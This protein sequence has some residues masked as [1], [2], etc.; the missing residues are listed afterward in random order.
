MTA[1]QIR[2]YT[3]FFAFSL[4][5]LSGLF[6]LVI[7]LLRLS[8]ENFAFDWRESFYGAIW[9]TDFGWET[10][11]FRVPPWSIPFFIPLTAL[12]FNIGWAVMMAFTTISLVLVVPRFPKNVQ[13]AGL[14]L[15]FTAYP[16]IRNYADVNLEA[17]VLLGLMLSFAAF[18]K[19]NPYLLALGVLLATIKPQNV[20]LLMLVI[21]SYMLQTWTK[22]NV[23]I[24]A[25]IVGAVVL[26][27]LVIWG[28]A[29]Y[30]SLTTTPT[31]VSLSATFASLSLPS[32]FAILLQIGIGLI[33][34]F[35]VL[36]GNKEISKLKAGLLIT[37]SVII[38]PYTNLTSLV[39]MLAFGGIALLQKRFW[40]GIIVFMLANS[41]YLY[42]LSL[43]S[44]D[45][46][47]SLWVTIIMTI[48]WLILLI[49]YIQ[50]EVL[51]PTEKTK[52]SN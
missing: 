2:N 7:P 27:S 44:L 28:R 41:P 36:R 40:L 47:S 30:T 22:R 34:L 15:L 26:A 10:H 13:R 25:G 3:L 29:W 6:L 46:D 32:W 21:G 5:L 37:A 42:R 23:L 51:V 38:A 4:L 9:R 24:F 11:P 31:G 45:L 18:Q 17:Y 43:V 49:V 20:S 1:Q 8:P 16:V 33:T 19:Q 39:S 48:T 50:E 14:I 35:V 52:E 12:P